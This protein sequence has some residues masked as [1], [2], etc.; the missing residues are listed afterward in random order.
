MTDEQAQNLVAAARAL[1]RIQLLTRM[2]QRLRTEHGGTDWNGAAKCPVCGGI[3]QVRTAAS[4]NIGG[5]C[6]TEGCASFFE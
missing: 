5:K 2:M 1:R 6:E 3:M 4:G